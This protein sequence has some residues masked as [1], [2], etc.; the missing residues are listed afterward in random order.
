[1]L[2]AEPENEEEPIV[3]I[4]KEQLESKRKELLNDLWWLQHSIISR[5][6]NLN[7]RKEPETQQS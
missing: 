4:T 3:D 5:R 2:E 1:M 6:Q 7:Q